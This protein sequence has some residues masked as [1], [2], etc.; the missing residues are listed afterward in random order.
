MIR[1][2][3][4]AAAA[5]KM[6]HNDHQ[7]AINFTEG[8]VIGKLI[9][10]SVPIIISELLQNLYNSVDSIVVGHYVGDAALAAVSVCTPI[11]QL[12][13]GFF[14]G[15]SIGNTVVTAKAFGSGDAEATRKAVRYA[16]SFSA[17]LGVA[18]SVLGI[19]MAPVFLDLTGCND[20]IYA[21]AITYLRIYLAGLMFTV[22][23]N[24]GTGILRAIGDSRT[25]LYIL[26]VTSLLNIG[27]DVLFVAVF[28]W[29]TAGVGIA[30]ILAQGLSMLLVA[31]VLRRRIDAPCIALGETWREGRKTVLSSVSIG[32]SAGLQNALIS[33]SNI[34][35][36]SYINRFPTYVAAGIGAANKVDR[37]VILPCKS[38][39]M[40]TTTF[41][42]QNL[43]ARNFDRAKKG[44]WY[45]LGICTAVTVPLTVLEYIFA[46][47]AIGLFS[48]EPAVIEAGAG[49]TRLLALFYMLLVIRDVLLGYLRGYGRSRMP[50]ILS[51]IG[52]VGIR[53]LFLAAATKKIGTLQVIYASFPIGWGAAM[54]LLAVYAL[55]VIR[56]MWRDAEAEPPAGR[57]Q[58]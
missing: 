7:H 3:Q 31:W 53:Q 42:S 40:T 4:R 30:T 16:F 9:L 29:G 26:A 54:L 32:F 17:A 19:L 15:M 41:V 35:V 8:R 44:F 57:L 20:E 49:M 52:M 18:V 22:I 58:A 27:L 5:G 51:L 23:Y 6:E 45:G 21:E 48:A 33:F 38:L 1:A 34:F 28:G 46:R 55:I 25:P 36:W 43:G 37:F 2:D 24:A 56:K 13:V 39:A 12:L 14:N 50:M 11:V 47:E 10:F